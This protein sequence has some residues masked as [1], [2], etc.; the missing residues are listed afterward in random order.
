MDQK[1]SIKSMENE[2]KVKERELQ[3]INQKAHLLSAEI[4]IMRNEIQNAKYRE[5]I[6]SLKEAIDQTPQDIEDIEKLK[7]GEK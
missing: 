5:T 4:G 1:S 2:I 6:A 3:M 7:G